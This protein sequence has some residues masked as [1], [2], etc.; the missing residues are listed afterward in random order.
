[1]THCSAH[2]HVLEKAEARY[3]DCSCCYSEMEINTRAQLFK[4][5]YSL[6]SSLVVKMLIVLVSTIPNSQVF[7]LKKCK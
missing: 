6:T 1:M 5:F 3:D 4:A 2:V 7:L